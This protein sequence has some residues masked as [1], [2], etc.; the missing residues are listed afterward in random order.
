MPKQRLTLLL[1]ALSIFVL[2]LAGCAGA[3]APA[4]S[5]SAAPAEEAAAPAPETAEGA[6]EPGEGSDTL[7]IAI[8]EDT[9]SYDPQRAFET[10]PS[11]VH[12]ATYQTLVTFPDGSV[13]SVVPDLAASW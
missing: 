13:E 7:V 9:A 2:I 12:K 6:E 1:A 8:A 5:D 11:I 10:L 3:P 4:T